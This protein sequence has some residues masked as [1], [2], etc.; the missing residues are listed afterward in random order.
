MHMSFNMRIFFGLKA[1]K[2]KFVT[3]AQTDTGTVNIIA[4]SGS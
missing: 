2:L 1:Y 3:Y 4:E